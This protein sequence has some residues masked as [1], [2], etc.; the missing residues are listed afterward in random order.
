MEIDKITYED[1]SLFSHEEEYSIF[2]KLDFTC[3]TGGKDLLLEYFNQP[4]SKLESIYATQQVLSLFLEKMDRWP[5]SISN[6]TIMVMERFYETAIDDI[7]Q[8]HNLP[9]ALTYKVFHAPDYSIVRYS[10]THFA[11]FVRGMSQLIGLLYTP[12]CPRLLSDLLE[13]ARGLLSQEALQSLAKL[14]P[15]VKLN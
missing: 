10:V 8:S 1:L 5:S 9:A 11:D 12:D 13:K 6:G 2:H 7:P 14:K 4:F 3:T 15:G